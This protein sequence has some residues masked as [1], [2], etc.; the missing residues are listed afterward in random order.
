MEA[1]DLQRRTRAAMLAMEEVKEEE[2][3]EMAPIEEDME[4]S[5][6]DYVAAINGPN[7]PIPMLTG[8]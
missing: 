6:S 7:G 2:D 3:N 1:Y 5:V 8:T 4:I